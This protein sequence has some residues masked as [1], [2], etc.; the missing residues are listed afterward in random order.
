MVFVGLSID[1]NVISL[2]HKTGNFDRQSGIG[3]GVFYDFSVRGISFDSWITFGY[4]ETYC[5]RKYE[6]DK[7][8]FKLLNIDNFSF[9][10]KVFH[11]ANCFFVEFYLFV[12]FL[13]HKSVCSTCFVEKLKMG[14]IENDVIEF[15]FSVK[16]AISDGTVLQVF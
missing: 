8:S 2:V 5:C 10:K 13:V 16:C 11:I 1:N 15:I 12:G 3:N 4:G 9:D 7:F 14:S 6:P